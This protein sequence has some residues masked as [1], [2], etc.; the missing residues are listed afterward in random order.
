MKSGFGESHH[1]LCQLFY[2]QQ[3]FVEQKKARDS[4]M[5]DALLLWSEVVHVLHPLCPRT[6]IAAETEGLHPE[7]LSDPV[8]PGAEEFHHH[9]LEGGGKRERRMMVSQYF[10]RILINLPN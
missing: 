5:V 10:I 8:L 2:K 6:Q 7:T 1:V 4:F 3:T 9:K